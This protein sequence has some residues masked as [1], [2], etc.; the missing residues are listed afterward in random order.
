MPGS[1]KRQELHKHLQK[2]AAQRGIPFTVSQ[3]IFQV[4]PSSAGQGDED[5]EGASTSDKNCLPYEFSYI[6]FG[7]DIARMSMQDKILLRPILQKIGSGAQVL[8]GNQESA[9]RILVFYHAHLL[10]TESCYLLHGLLEEASGI[11]LWLTSELPLPNR[12]SDYFLE[13]PVKGK[14]RSLL[15]LGTPCPPSWKDV[16]LKIFTK[17][18]TGGKPTISDT[19]EVRDLIYEI[20]MRNLRWV[21]CIHILLDVFLEM[22]LPPPQRQTLLAILAQQ[23]ATA[24]GQTIPSY[25]IPLLWEALFLRLR[26]ALSQ[27]KLDGDR[28]AASPG[29]P[30][31]GGCKTPA[32][33]SGVAKRGAH[34]GGHGHVSKTGSGGVTV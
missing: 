4:S 3:R 5:G 34:A 31:E 15:A 20:L 7:F 1:G 24:S 16:F 17:W 12:L 28:S 8:A 18:N 29:S 6:H 23:E 19:T 13:I 25:R 32:R 26:E 14:D 21:E 2:V 11:S 27:E 33:K 10:S 30:S 9:H 22:K